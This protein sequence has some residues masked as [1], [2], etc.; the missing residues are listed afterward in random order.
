MTFRN[1]ANGSSEGNG[2]CQGIDT[3]CI[4]SLFTARFSLSLG[5][6]R[7]STTIDTPIFLRLS[8]PSTPGCPPRKRFGETS[9]KFGRP[10]QSFRLPIDCCEG[11]AVFWQL[12]WARR[13]DGVHN[14]KR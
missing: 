12:P 8:N 5:P 11:G 9:P 13:V 1:F 3:Y 14:R 10:T 4:P 7:I 2:Q 6:L